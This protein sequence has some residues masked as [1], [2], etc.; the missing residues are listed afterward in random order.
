MNTPTCPA[1]GRTIGRV[2]TLSVRGAVHRGSQIACAPHRARGPNTS[3]VGPMRCTWARHLARGT[4]DMRVGSA[5]HAHVQRFTCVS[6]G[7]PRIFSGSRASDTPCPRQFCP[8]RRPLRPYEP[9][10]GVF[11]R[12]GLH[13]GRHA[14][15]NR[16]LTAPNRDLTAPNRD[17]TATKRKELRCERRT[18]ELG[19]RRGHRQTGGIAALGP[20]H[21]G[22]TPW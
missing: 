10:V 1:C 19:P 13:F 21:A 3:R 6:R 11:R 8:K 20:R 7:L 18:V 9:I 5:A 14:A 22:D 2:R 17:L 4:D 16:D 12:G 15:P